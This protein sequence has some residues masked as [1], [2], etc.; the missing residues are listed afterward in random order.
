M[1]T[2]QRRDAQDRLDEGGGGGSE[3]RREVGQERNHTERGAAQ[4]PRRHAQPQPRRAQNHKNQVDQ[5]REEK[6]R[7]SPRL[8]E[9][10]A[11]E[12]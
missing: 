7:N 8:Q 2:L 6:R 5:Q 9:V 12:R 11:R 4:P 3:G 10:S 1:V